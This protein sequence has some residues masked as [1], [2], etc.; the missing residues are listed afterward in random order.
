MGKN[1]IYLIFVLPL[2][3]AVYQFGVQINLTLDV[4]E[5]RKPSPVEVA[6]S[7]VVLKTVV[8]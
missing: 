8:Q 1:Q 5:K 3:K 2:E 4:I 7:C 6:L